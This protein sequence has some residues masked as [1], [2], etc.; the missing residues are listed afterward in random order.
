MHDIADQAELQDPPGGDTLRLRFSGPF[1]GR[2]V[3]WEAELLTLAAWQK[4]HPEE[5]TERK[6]LIEIEV[7]DAQRPH[8]TVALD[9]AQIDLPTVRKAMLMVRQYK[10]LRRGRHS[11]G[12]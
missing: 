11:F 6:N 5:A 8:I 7:K 10:R 12:A 3:R 1:E 2:E 4:R 9:V